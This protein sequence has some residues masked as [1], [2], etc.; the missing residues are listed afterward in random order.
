MKSK[1]LAAGA[2]GCAVWLALSTTPAHIVRAE[3]QPVTARSEHARAI[4]EEV[5]KTQE[6]RQATAI[7]LSLQL[8]QYQK[9]LLQQL[10]NLNRNL[11]KIAEQLKLIAGRIR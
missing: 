5:M 1:L 4:K 11:S 10:M 7:E 3:L 8:N 9:Q 6:V 2:I